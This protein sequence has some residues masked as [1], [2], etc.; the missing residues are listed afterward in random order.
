MDV[1]CFQIAFCIWESA[2]IASPAFMQILD[3]FIIMRYNI[4][5]PSKKSRRFAQ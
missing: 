4:I 3:F 2:G 1:N 5:K